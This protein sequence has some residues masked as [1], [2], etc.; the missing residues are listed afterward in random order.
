MGGLTYGEDDT[1]EWLQ[2]VLRAHGE[3]E[4]TNALN[5]PAEV[6]AAVLRHHPGLKPTDVPAPH[7]GA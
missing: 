6:T 1:Y 3:R 2:R 5:I 7:H 4:R